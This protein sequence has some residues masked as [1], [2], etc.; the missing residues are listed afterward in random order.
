MS[1]EAVVTDSS[2]AIPI[3]PWMLKARPA[4]DETLLARIADGD[5]AA[6]QSFHNRY[7]ARVA[8]FARQL[9][10]DRQLDED[11]VQEVFTSVWTRAASYNPERGDA[12]GWLYTLTRNKVIDLWR[13]NS[14]SGQ[15]EEIDDRRHFR[16]GRPAEEDDLR[17]T[18]RQALSHVP[19]EQRRAIE[20]AYFD[21]LTYQETAQELE[22][23]EGT[24]KSRIRLG[25]RTMRSVLTQGRRA[26]N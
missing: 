4:G 15:T 21:G 2:T 3:Q 26:A 22:L 6:F 5:L 16:G 14:K 19:P 9:N 7:A 12:A 17:L 10:H 1:F 8:G 24:L 23:P 11:I 20:M 13:R 18:L 25:L